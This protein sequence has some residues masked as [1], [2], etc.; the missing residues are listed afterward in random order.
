MKHI[1]I[2]L[3]LLLTLSANKC[4]EKGTAMADLKGTKWVFQTLAG[5]ALSMPKGVETPWLQ[6]ADGGVQGHGG[7]NRLMGGYEQDGA[8]LRIMDLASTKMYCDGVMDTENTIKSTLGEVD[9]YPMNGE[10][11]QLLGG[12][13]VLATLKGEAAGTTAPAT[14]EDY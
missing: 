8:K 3:T 2:A 1:A 7:C 11:L 4:R 14:K 9:A 5:N 12:G 10:V 6:L 13:R